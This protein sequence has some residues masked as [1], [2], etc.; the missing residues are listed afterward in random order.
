VA[1]GGITDVPTH[2][3]RSADAPWRALNGA[4]QRGVWLRATTPTS[5]L[6]LL[7]EQLGLEFEYVRDRLETVFLDGK[8]VDDLEHSVVRDGSTVTLSAAMPGL[9]G[10]T[11]RRDGFYKAMRAE[12]TWSTRGDG[13]PTVAPA[14]GLV[15]VKLFNLILQEVG[16]RLLSRGVLLDREMAADVVGRIASENADRPDGRVLILVDAPGAVP[17]G[18]GCS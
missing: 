15:R 8:V 16:P 5:L 3:Y 10:A 7:T 1:A 9:V 13:D 18:P 14:P 6:A 17:E 4:L 12:I 11:L 2:H